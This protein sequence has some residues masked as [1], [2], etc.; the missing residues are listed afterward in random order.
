MVV[1]D[2]D[3]VSITSPPNETDP[4]LIVDS[5]AVLSRSISRELLETITWRKAKISNR[6]GSVEDGELAISG[7]LNLDGEASTPSSGEDLFSSFSLE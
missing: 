4:P 5:Y 2:L 1:D 6:S 3:I 7:A